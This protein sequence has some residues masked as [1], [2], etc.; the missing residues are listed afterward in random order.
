MD[1]I[2]DELGTMENL[3]FVTVDNPSDSV[4][5]S[6]EGNNSRLNSETR[7]AAVNG[8]DHNVKVDDETNK[9]IIKK[10]L[11]VNCSQ[12]P[13]DILEES[14]FCFAI[15]KA[16][17]FPK[18]YEE[19]QRAMQSVVSQL[20]LDTKVLEWVQK[21]DEKS[22]GL[23][24]YYVLFFTYVKKNNQKVLWF[25]P[26][27]ITWQDISNQL[28]QIH[29]PVTN[30]NYNPLILDEHWWLNEYNND[31]KHNTK[32]FVTAQDVIGEIQKPKLKFMPSMEVLNLCPLVFCFILILFYLLY[33]HVD[34]CSSFGKRRYDK[35]N[36]FDSA[37]VP[38]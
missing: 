31:N 5:T 24:H 13:Q 9:K 32:F 22:L 16:H 33:M 10:D 36:R 15:G 18:T 29:D 11:N 37:R 4:H 1:K 19:K 7:A 30:K 14:I 34:I 35:E 27:T 8:V 21:K 20:N 23:S 28:Q 25:E 12:I 17:L 38:K 26:L 6:G 2:D 3:E